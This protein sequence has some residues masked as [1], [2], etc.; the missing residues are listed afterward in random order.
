LET[1]Y[2]E[3]MSPFLPRLSS[4][5]IYP[6]CIPWC[7]VVAGSYFKYALQVLGV[8]VEQILASS[9]RPKSVMILI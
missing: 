6:E 3:D 5:P 9:P 8:R 4:S 1:F 7:A 2:E